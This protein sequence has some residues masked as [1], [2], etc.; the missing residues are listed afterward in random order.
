MGT[1][2]GREHA[3]REVTHLLRERGLE[4]DSGES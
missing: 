1:E 3:R 2:W 4:I